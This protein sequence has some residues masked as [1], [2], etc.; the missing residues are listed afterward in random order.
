M[1]L[2]DP[3]TGVCVIKMSHCAFDTTKDSNVALDTNFWEWRVLYRIIT[4]AVV[5]MKHPNGNVNF[6]SA[7]DGKFYH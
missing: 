4:R 7:L 6:G 2:S 5:E 3:E 1:A